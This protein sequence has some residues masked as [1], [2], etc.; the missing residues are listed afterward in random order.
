MCFTVQ[1]S[2]FFVV[3]VFDSLY[4]LSCCS[5]FVKNFFQLFEVFFF[6]RFCVSLFSYQGS[7]LLSFSTACIFYH[8]VL[9]L[10]RTFFNFLKFFSSIGFV[11]SCSNSDILSHPL[12]LSFSTACIFYHAVLSL[13][14]TFFNFLKFFSSIGFVLSCSNSDILSHLLLFVNNFFNLFFRWLSVVCRR[15][16]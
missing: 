11:L 9:S 15:H 10:S 4:I 1:L 8:A 2:R 6:N 7:L 13:S 14:R 3:V 16:L 12:L 5:V